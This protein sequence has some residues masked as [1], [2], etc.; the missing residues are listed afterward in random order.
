MS[1]RT[2]LAGAAV[3]LLLAGSVAVYAT[4]TNLDRRG[5][6]VTARV[7]WFP[8][9]RPAAQAVSVLITVNGV[10][11]PPGP[12]R[13][14]RGFN[15]VYV[16]SEG[17]VLVVHAAGPGQITADILDHGGAEIVADEAPPSPAECSYVAHA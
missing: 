7:Y 10:P 14:T 6:I 11:N 1:V 3:V 15:R 2:R 8:K 4:R 16:L 5:L 13:Y 12:Q 9:D 17:D